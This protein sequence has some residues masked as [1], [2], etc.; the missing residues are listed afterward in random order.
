MLIHEQTTQPE[1]STYPT[2]TMGIGTIKW[3][4]GLSYPT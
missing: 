2:V 3:A 4:I 1:E